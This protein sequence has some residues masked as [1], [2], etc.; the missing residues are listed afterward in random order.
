MQR[1]LSVVKHFAKKSL[2]NLECIEAWPTEINCI[3]QDVLVS[4]LNKLTIVWK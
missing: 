3:G 4:L 2:S 1:A